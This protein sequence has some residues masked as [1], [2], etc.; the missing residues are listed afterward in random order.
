DQAR[1][2]DSFSDKEKV[3]LDVILFFEVDSQELV[4]RLSA[5]RQCGACKEVY[6]LVKRPPKT[7][8]KCDLCSGDLTQRPDDEA[9]VVQERLRVYQVQTS[10]ILDYYKGRG[11]LYMINAAQ[12]IDR[13]FAEITAIIQTR[14]SHS[15]S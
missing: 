15:P 1:A 13:V 3:V 12:D 5:R 10:P 9:S 4:K 2:L 14:E 11:Q 6:N 8:G 7:E